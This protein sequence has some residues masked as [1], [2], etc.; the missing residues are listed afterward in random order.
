M[1]YFG[2]VLS[3]PVYK[4]LVESVEIKLKF[5]LMDGLMD[6][7]SRKNLPIRLSSS[8]SRI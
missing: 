1:G 4:L 8:R 6:V 5:M 3:I 7:L 2:K